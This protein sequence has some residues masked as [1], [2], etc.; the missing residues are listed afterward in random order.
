MLTKRRFLS[1]P[2]VDPSQAKGKRDQREIQHCDDCRYILCLARFWYLFSK[3]SNDTGVNAIAPIPLRD[4]LGKGFAYHRCRPRLTPVKKIA[5]MFPMLQMLNHAFAT[6]TTKTLTMFKPEHRLFE[7]Q[8]LTLQP[9]DMDQRPMFRMVLVQ[10]DL[11]HVI[12]FNSPQ[13]HPTINTMDTSWLFTILWLR[14]KNLSLQLT[15]CVTH[16]FWVTWSWL[17]LIYSLASNTIKAPDEEAVGF[18]M[19]Y[20]LIYHLG[21]R[22]TIEP[23]VLHSKWND[24]KRALKACG[25]MG[26]VLKGT[27]MSNLSHGFFLGGKN[28]Q[29]KE[30]VLEHLARDLN[31]EDYMVEIGFDRDVRDG[32]LSAEQL[33]EDIKDWH[34]H[35]RTV[36]RGAMAF[37]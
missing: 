7:G 1:R 23:E 32:A 9:A 31:I 35:C 8:P 2:P 33:L 26:A 37:W 13:F 14:I 12:F 24:A 3:G 21:L 36:K 4:N 25:L 5:R 18:K 29:Q 10:F 20:M 34:S 16:I 28:H 17:H 22:A 30:E 11:V 15:Q 19:G 27:V 6:V